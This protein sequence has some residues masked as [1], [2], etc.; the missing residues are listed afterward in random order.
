M[1][2]IPGWSVGSIHLFL[3]LGRRWPRILLS[4]A[5][6]GGVT[7]LIAVSLLVPWAAPSGIWSSVD[8]DTVLR[9]VAAPGASEAQVVWLPSRESEATTARMLMDIYRA[10]DT[11]IRTPQRWLSVL[12][13]CDLLRAAEAPAVLSDAPADVVRQRY[14]CSPGV[15]VI[16]VRR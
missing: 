3:Y 9:A 14:A 16:M 11:P 15:R 4:P 6:K 10:S 5:L 12:E 2:S 7:S 13:E 8:P 1:A